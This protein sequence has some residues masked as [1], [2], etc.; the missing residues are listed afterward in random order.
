[1]VKVRPREAA[2]QAAAEAFLARH[3]SLRGARLGQL[4][5]PMDHPGLCPRARVIWQTADVSSDNPADLHMLNVIVRDMAASLDFYQR[6]G[7]AIP[8]EAAGDHVQL[9]MPGGFS[10]EL[11]HG[12]VGPAVAR[13]LCRA[14]PAS[15]RVVLGF[16][17]ASRA[18]VD[19]RYAELIAT[20]YR[21]RQRPFDAF[22]GARYAVVADPDGNDVGL[23]SPVEESR[24][25]WLPQPSPAP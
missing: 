18:A 15:A 3:N 22:W 25:T 14:D 24:R 4:V 9:K 11:G 12:R 21:G 19:D 6:L 8:G 20:G 5:H 17:L 7:I 10:L 23:M 1:M 2:D 16:M 13:R